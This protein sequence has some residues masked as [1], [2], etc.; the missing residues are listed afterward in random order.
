VSQLAIESKPVGVQLRDRRI[1]FATLALIVVLA[2]VYLLYMDWGM[3]HMEAVANMIIMPAMTHWSV[4]D[5]I[6]VCLM[7][8]IM[9]IA[10]MI[11]SAS[12]AILLFTEVS[13]R[14]A[15][16]NNLVRTSY[17]TLGYLAVWT[18]FSAVA[19]LAQWALLSAALVSP[20]MKSTS[21]ILGAGLLFVAGLFQLSPFK[22]ACLA[23]CRSPIGFFLTEWRAGSWGAF[24][25][26]LKHGGYCL[27]CCW[28]MMSLL[29]AF[30]VMNLFWVAGLSIFVLVEKVAPT[31]RLV[32]GA[33]GVTF[34]CWGGWILYST[35]PGG[36]RGFS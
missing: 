27:G 2:W 26:G 21:E 5:L 31:K 34:I 20:M 36:T 3:R 7:W 6:L 14:E 9:M 13:R 24:R 22:D 10:M 16:P 19:T 28:A 4:W 30:G 23:H 32:S 33:A 15:R 11:P 35:L 1:I 8:T 12:P 18:G 25:M 17:F 29:F